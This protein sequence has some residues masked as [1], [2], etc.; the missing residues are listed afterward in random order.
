MDVDRLIAERARAV[1]ASGIREVFRRRA[2]IADPID[3]SIGQPDF[4]VPEPVK[5]RAVRA[6]EEDQHGYTLTQGITPLIRRAAQ[7]LER[8]I[9]WPLA[10]SESSMIITDGTS[11][12]LHIAMLAL[13]NPGD[14]IILSDPYF[15]AYPHMARLCGATPVLCDTYPDF[16]MTAERLEPLITPRTKAVLLNSPS[17]P[18]GSVMSARQCADVLELCRRKGVLL[19]SDEIYDEFCYS[20]AVQPT[21]MPAGGPRC[22][23]PC[24]VKGS[25]DSILLIRGFGKTYGCTGWRMGYTVGPR[26]LI[27]QMLKMQQYSFV[28]APTPLQWACI[29]AFDVDMR[30]L[31]DAYERKRD[32]VHQRLAPL[33]GMT[34]PGG[35]FY[36]YVPVP[37][38]AASGGRAFF[39]KAAAERVLIVPGDVFSRRDSH[40]RLSFATKDDT[41]ERGLDV[42]ERLL[43]G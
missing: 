24:R 3:F 31:V 38:R 6:I 28:C 5:R 23:S 43:K 36:A 37:A 16:L 32:R 12:A 10:H 35:A 4:A 27:E 9:G 20:D 40:F 42:L 30:P 17:N 13:L 1:E 19:I 14:E 22:P 8:D 15:V 29:E 33:T 7:H 11:G 34:R 25:E 18:A 26:P 2:A 39:E 41:L 21:G